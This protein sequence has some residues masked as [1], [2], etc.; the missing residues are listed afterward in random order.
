MDT[1]RGA[2]LN[3]YAVAQIMNLKDGDAVLALAP[4][5]HITGLVMQVLLAFICKAP[6]VLSYRFD[7]NVMLDSIREYRP[8]MVTGPLTAYIAMMDNPTSSR[9]D[10][11]SFKVVSSGGAAVMPAVVEQ[12]EEKFGHY[13]YQGYGLTETNGPVI[14]VDPMSRGRIDEE[15]NALSIGKALPHVDARVIDENDQ[16]VGP[17][18]EG[19]IVVA[20][21]SRFLRYWNKPEETEK[22]LLNGFLRTGDVGFMDEDGWFYIVDRKKDMINASGYKVWPRE[23]EDVIYSHPSVREVVVVGV[24]DG[25]RGETVKAFVSLKAGHQTSGDEIKEYCKLHMAAYKYPRAV[26][27]LEDL[28]KT[29]S[30]KLLRRELRDRSKMTA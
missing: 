29:S 28:P 16:F 8:A 19:E 15:R 5:F 18:V 23:V 7:A 22:S 9:S 11:S 1:H 13:I 4:L 20:G 26:E 17:N 30:G 10:F 6:I 24:P 14:V 3:A 12:F 2:M 27:F 25:Y 21:D